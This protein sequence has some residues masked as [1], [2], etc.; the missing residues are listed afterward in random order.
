MHRWKVKDERFIL[1]MHPHGVVP[2]QAFLWA[3]YCDQY[4]RTDEHGTV[5]GFGGMASVIFRFPV[6]RTIMG[7]LSGVAATYKSLKSGM[8]GAVFARPHPT[9]SP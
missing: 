3:A 1:G 4:M 9:A 5:Y 6:L 8:T 2:I 7:W